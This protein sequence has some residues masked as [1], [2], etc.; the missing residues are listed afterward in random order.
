MFDQCLNSGFISNISEYIKSIPLEKLEGEDARL[1]LQKYEG[2]I[3]YML[4]NYEKAALIERKRLSLLESV[5]RAD[6]AELISSYSRVGLYLM[7]N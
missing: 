3:E 2:K 7:S 4:G 6:S 1:T 5:G